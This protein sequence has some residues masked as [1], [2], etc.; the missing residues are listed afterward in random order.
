N[1][2][3]PRGKLAEAEVFRDGE[4][5]AEG[6]FLVH[7]ANAGGH[8]I[9]GTPEPRGLAVNDQ[10]AFVG[11]VDTRQDFAERALPGAILAAERVTGALCNVEAHVPQRLHAGEAL[12]DPSKLDDGSAH[13]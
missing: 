8:R 10:F 1:E 6:E 11:R 5:F 7:D 9:A 3:C 12:A 2:S 4:V 13:C